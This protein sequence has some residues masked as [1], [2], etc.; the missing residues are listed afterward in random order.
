MIAGAAVGLGTL[1]AQ[2]PEMHAFVLGSYTTEGDEVV[3][4]GMLGMV[5]VLPRSSG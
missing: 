2:L 3:S 1:S 5:W 4:I